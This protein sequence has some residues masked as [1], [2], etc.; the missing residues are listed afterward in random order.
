MTLRS[1]WHRIVYP[2]NTQNDY[3]DRRIVQLMALIFIAITPLGLIAAII[4][5]I[6]KGENFFLDQE[7]HLMLI[8]ILFVIPLYFLSRSKYYKQSGIILISF[9]SIAIFWAAAPIGATQDIIAF[10][11]LIVPVILSSLFYSKRA[12]IFTSITNGLALATIPILVFKIPIAS[13]LIGPLLFFIILCTFIWLI[14]HYQRQLNQNR[15]QHVQSQFNQLQILYQLTNQVTHANTLDEIYEVAINA[16]CNVLKVDRTAIMLFDTDGIIRFKASVKLSEQYQK[17]VTGHSPW[18]S[19]EKEPQPILIADI[20]TDTQLV[21]LHDVILQEGI[22][23]IAFIPLIYRSLLLGKFML[24][25]N[26]PHHYTDSEI[27]LAQTISG[28]ISLGLVR[29]MAEKA[30][31]Q[32]SSALTRSNMFIAALSH[33]ATRI[34]STPELGQ[35]FLTLGTELKQIDITCMLALLD[36]ETQDLVVRYSSITPELFQQLEQQLNGKYQDVR[37]IHT[38]W[39]NNQSIMS[40]NPTFFSDPTKMIATFIDRPQNELRQITQTAGMSSLSGV[41]LLPLM[42]ENRVNGLLIVWGDDLG[43]SD[44]TAFSVF[45]GQVSIIIERTRL[46]EV[47]REGEE[48]YRVVSELVSDW[49]YAY[50]VNVDNQFVRNW[51]TDAFERA[52][53][54]R[55]NEFLSETSWEHIVHPDDREVLQIRKQSLLSG[56]AITNEYRIVTKSGEVKWIRDYSLPIIDPITDSVTRIYGA[57]QDITAL[58]STQERAYQRQ[59]IES[60]GLMAGGVAHDFNNLLVAMMGQTSLALAKMPQDSAGRV[61]IEKAVKATERAAELTQQM[62]AYSGHGY[63]EKVLLDLRKVIQNNLSI[64]EATISKQIKIIAKLPRSVPLIK[65]DTGQIQQVVMNLIINAAEAIGDTPGF[66]RIAVKTYHL[67]EEFIHDKHINGASLMPGEYVYLTVADNGEGME[68]ETQDRIFDPFFTTKFTGRG[69]GLAAVLG[70][71]QAHDGGIFV[72]SV[73]GKGT[74]FHLF[75]PISTEG[76]SGVRETAVSPYTTKQSAQILLIEDETAVCEAISDILELASITVYTAANGLDGILIYKE[77]QDEID[78]IML[79]ISMP[80]LSGEE[81]FHALQQLNPKAKIIL[82]SGYNEAEIVERFKGQG[83]TGFIQKP[84]RADTLLQE[85]KQYLEG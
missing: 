61:H 84:Y 34:E 57:A 24:Y 50:K 69:L 54:Y 40:G 41:I 62:L 78:L 21:D 12:F 9:S 85:L 71:I 79:D 60:L 18:G 20:Q 38:Q 48:R 65:G 67:D 28:H 22:R 52:T 14:D 63:F 59:K 56:K 6:I 44:L 4:P 26:T 75:F 27:Q 39:A 80:G 32:K 53:G 8:I 3:E 5:P 23:S 64:L 83:L 81:T 10:Y 58:R 66:V 35:V 55:P 76:M 47:L 13:I 2:I 73:Q 19:D 15:H 77:K 68:A 30:I 45:A 25:Y 11:Y 17:S 46:F 70:I 29:K 82:S 36:K 49:A 74:T 1:V 51:T 43:E 16:L 33:V 42:V 37:I 31:L 7:F 72:E